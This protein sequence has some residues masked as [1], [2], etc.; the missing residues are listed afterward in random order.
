ME[1]TELHKIP[2]KILKS[3]SEIIIGKKDVLEAIMIAI[4]SEGHILL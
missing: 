4:L 3:A 1:Q 2:E